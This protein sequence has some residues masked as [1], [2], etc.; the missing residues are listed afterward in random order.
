MEAK[1]ALLRRARNAREACGFFGNEDGVRREATHDAVQVLQELER[2]V[3][4]VAAVLV[5]HPLAG[6]LA[7]VEVEHGCHSVHTQAVAVEFLEPVHRVCN[8]EV[9]DFVAAQVEDVCAPVRMF[10]LARVGMLVAGGAIKAA[11]RVSV[12][13]E[14]CRNPVE[15]HADFVLVAKV[16]K[17]AELVGRTVAARGGVVPG[18]LVAPGFVERVFRERQKFY[19][20]VAHLLEVGDKRFG[21]FVPVEEAVGISRVAPPGARMDFVNIHRRS[22]NLRC[23]VRLHVEVVTPFVAV[24]VSGNGGR[25]RADFAEL[26][27]RVHLHVQVA[28]GAVNLEAVEFAFAEVRDEYFPD[29]RTA[30][31]AHLVTP[32]VPAVEAAD[33]GNG[34]CVRSPY[35]ELHALESLVLHEVCAQLAVELVVRT[36][37]NQVSVEFAKYGLEGVRVGQRVFVLVALLDDE[38]VEERL[39]VHVQDGFEEPCIAELYKIKLHFAVARFPTNKGCLRLVCADD[40]LD[41]LVCFERVDAENREW[42]SCVKVPYGLHVFCGKAS[43]VVPIHTISLVNS[44]FRYIYKKMR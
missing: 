8:E 10:A 1:A 19:V 42:V 11:K 37:R 41:S 27:E 29:A 35:G 32:A 16:Y 20:G 15:N 21:K 39:V 44:F 7:V 38:V 17:V 25:G 30:E 40:G 3:V 22:E 36:G 43:K 12:L 24:E 9:L 33:D 18:H 2:I 13:G 6:A 34:F 4:D 14:V 23:P 26:C 31:H 5:R 28:I